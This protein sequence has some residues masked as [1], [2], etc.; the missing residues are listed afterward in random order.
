MV[1][2]IV[3]LIFSLVYY[4][5]SF[6]TNKGVEF[7]TYLLIT[8][9]SFVPFVIGF[10]LAMPLLSVLS[11]YLGFIVLFILTIYSLLI[12]IVSVDSFLVKKDINT[13]ILYNILNYL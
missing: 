8:T 11:F 7:Y 13:V 9:M 4:M 5:T 6:F 3:I 12:F 10:T 2:V 1:S